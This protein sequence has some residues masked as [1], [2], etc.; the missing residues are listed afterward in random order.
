[1]SGRVGLDYAVLFRVLDD[2]FTDRDEW[3]SVFEDIQTIEGAALTYF[4]ESH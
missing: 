2:R 3:Q 4:A 1:M